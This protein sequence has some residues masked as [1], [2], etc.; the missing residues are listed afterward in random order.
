MKNRT[1]FLFP[2]QGAQYPGIGSDLCAEYLTCKEI[3][4]RASSELSYDMIELS[5]DSTSNRIN[6]TKYTQPV[7]L[8]H[9]YACL[10]VFLEL[11]GGSVVPSYACGHSLGEYSALLSAEAF[12]FES[13]LNLVSTRGH[14]M[15]GCGGG[16][17][18]AISMSKE[19]IEPLLAPSGCEISACNLP[20]QTVVGGWPENIDELLSQLEKNH[21]KQGI[22]LKTEG[23]FHTSHMR[24]A[25]EMFRPIL[26]ATQFELPKFPVSSNTTGRFHEADIDVIRKNLYMQLTQPVQW[27]TSL[28][29]IAEEGI[30]FV[31]EFGGG[32]G[33]KLS[34][35]SKR[36]NLARMIMQSYR[37]LKPR[38]KYCS[39]INVDTLL[40]ACEQISNS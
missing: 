12:S 40:T 26:Q 38:P 30:D 21:G 27:H 14:C 35:A 19:E 33:P 29:Q 36:P 39:V 2:G 24:P 13:A 6:L 8:T 15:A 4:E 16:Q 7:L 17:M 37:R 22:R 11:M 10:S 34:P 25:A 3:Y 1:L 32:L 23:A 18:V 28:M 20:K 5:N 31:I 9:S